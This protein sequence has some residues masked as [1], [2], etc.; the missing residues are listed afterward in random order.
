MLISFFHNTA[1]VEQTGAP[2][3]LWEL[4]PGISGFYGIL[5]FILIKASLNIDNNNGLLILIKSENLFHGI[6]ID[7]NAA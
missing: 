1:P 2:P 4:F 5:L 6:L 7:R 3:F